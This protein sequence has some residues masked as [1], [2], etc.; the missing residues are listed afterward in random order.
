MKSEHR[1]ELKTNEL[2]QWI[3]DFPQW[4][5]KNMRMITYV[6]VATIVVIAYYAWYNYQENVVLAR[7]QE[8][9]TGLLSKLAQSK[10]KVLEVQSQGQDYSFILN[11]IAN[12]LDD[13]AQK[14]ENEQAA[15]LA[16]T[17]KAEALRIELHYRLVPADRQNAAE[18]INR[19]KS[20]YSRAI[21]MAH[22]NPP[23]KAIATYGLGL[24][25]EELGNFDQA[26]QI[27]QQI[28]EDTAFQGTVA[29]VLSENRLKVMED[30]REKVVFKAPAIK[31]LM[32]NEASPFDADFEL[33]AKQST[34]T[35]VVDIPNLPANQ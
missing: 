21:E 1:H 11:Q 26:R 19:A 4:A 18:Q 13:F 17:K 30:Y 34:E 12:E 25:E 5:K 22:A 6:S 20:D 23:L 9:L 16:L 2:A 15:A 31:T 32:E 8:R 3:A 10:Q 28:T 7:E 24:C 35:M 14:A 29:A 33:D 27:Y